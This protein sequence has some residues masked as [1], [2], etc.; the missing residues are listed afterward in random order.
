MEFTK[1]IEKVKDNLKQLKKVVVAFSGGKDSFFL[2]KL[3]VETLG[4]ANVI[5]FYVRTDLLCENDEKRVDYFTK[6]L[7]FN[8][9]RIFIDVTGE[10]KIMSNPVD[11][12][13][14][15]KTKIKY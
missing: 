12:C 7:D 14:F 8:L 15:C 1:K 13:Y 4:K 2:L 10:E 5:A 9:K 6:R 11:R 3:A